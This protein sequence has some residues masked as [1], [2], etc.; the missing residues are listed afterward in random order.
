MTRRSSRPASRT[1]RRVSAPYPPSWMDRVVD[2]IRRSPVGPSAFYFAMAV[3]GATLAHVLVWQLGI[4]P[5][6]HFYSP[7]LLWGAW[8]AYPFAFV[9]Y[10]DTEAERA[11]DSFRPALD[12]APAQLARLR[13]ELTTMPA[14]PVLMSSLALVGVAAVSNWI[15]PEAVLPFVQASALSAIFLGATFGL[16][17]F[18]GGLMYHTYHQM[19]TVSRLYSGAGSF[20][21]FHPASAYAFSGLTAQTGAGWAL[22]IYLGVWLYPD[23][24]RNPVWPI[25]SGGLLLAVFLSFGSTLI[26]IHQK[27]EHEKTIRLSEIGRRMETAFS[28]LHARLDRGRMQG[29]GRVQQIIPSLIAE[30]DVLSRIPTWP[31]RPGTL[32]G[33]LSALL[34]PAGVLILR[35]LIVRFVGL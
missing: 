26:R 13:Y 21:L 29:A 1:S 30:R 3:L 8:S 16:Y 25:V 4:A 12:L 7:A 5:V 32:A 24:L 22:F 2:W 28:E 15:F 17:G 31:W 6:G 9:H 18:T 20:S 27:M 11:F 14:R 34:L 33:F 10:L 23:L 35:D 19:Q